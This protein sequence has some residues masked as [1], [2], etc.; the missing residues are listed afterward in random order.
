MLK[1][2]FCLPW[3]LVWHLRSES[4]KESAGHNVADGRITV[5]TGIVRVAIGDLGSRKD[6][7]AVARI[8]PEAGPYVSNEDLRLFSDAFRLA[9]WSSEVAAFRH[10]ST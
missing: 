1:S 5:A 7:G 10:A 2:P 4:A 9:T 3:P 8:C 6:D